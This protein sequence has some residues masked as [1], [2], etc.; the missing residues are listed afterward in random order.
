MKLKNL[1]FIMILASYLQAI[2][3]I[4]L[5]TGTRELQPTLL[6]IALYYVKNAGS[7]QELENKLKTLD[8]ETKKQLFKSWRSRR[9]IQNILDIKNINIYELS[10]LAIADDLENLVKLIIKSGLVDIDQLLFIAEYYQNSDILDLLVI[11]GANLDSQINGPT[12]LMLA[13]QKINIPFITK[14]LELGADPNIEDED[15]DTAIFWLVN[16]FDSEEIERDKH[17]IDLLIDAGANIDH[18]NNSDSNVLAEYTK[19]YAEDKSV[20]PMMEYLIF[21]GANRSIALAHL[22]RILAETN[23]QLSATT[24][25]S[26]DLD[27][28]NL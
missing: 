24:S 21:K 3:T 15:G 28:Q 4:T 2:D 16:H 26:T 22:K 10:S 17:I 7:V 5:K 12:V 23:A 13:V 14:L 20:T 9:I 27:L 1:L 8:I 11:E 25:S 6:E 18:I 19:I